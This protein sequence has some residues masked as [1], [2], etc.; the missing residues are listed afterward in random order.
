MKLLLDELENRKE[1]SYQDIRHKKMSRRRRG[2]KG[3][4]NK[5]ALFFKSV[6]EE[7]I[8]TLRWSITQGMFCTHVSA[9]VRRKFGQKFR[10]TRKQVVSIPSVRKMNR[11]TLRYNSQ[12][13]MEP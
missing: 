1:F 13:Y 3:G 9:C 7:N 2:G 8:P 5:R 4:G 12:L 11:V 10:I 6:K